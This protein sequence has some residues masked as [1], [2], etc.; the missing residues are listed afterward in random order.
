VS[1]RD[2]KELQKVAKFPPPSVMMGDRGKKS[3]NEISAVC[4]K[5]TQREENRCVVGKRLNKTI[6]KGRE[7]T[8]ALIKGNLGGSESRDK[9]ASTGEQRELKENF[10]AMNGVEE[11]DYAERP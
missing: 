8:F 6:S 10:Q 5:R 9:S 7:R 11:G 3:K 2:Q 1:Q 4:N